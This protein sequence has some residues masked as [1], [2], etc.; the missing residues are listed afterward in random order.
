MIIFNSLFE[1]KISGS[2]HLSRYEAYK[3]TRRLYEVYITMDQR[4]TQGCL[5]K[6]D[7]LLKCKVTTPIAG[8]MT[9][10]LLRSADTVSDLWSKSAD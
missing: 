9:E 3:P 6:W 7:S 5:I 4:S 1:S 8:Y 2:A 10:E